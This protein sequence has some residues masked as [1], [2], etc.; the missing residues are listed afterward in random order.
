MQARRE[1]NVAHKQDL[2]QQMHIDRLKEQ[3]DEVMTH[4]ELLLNAPLISRARE[5]LSIN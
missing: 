5:V 2:V 4:Q 3:P 1:R